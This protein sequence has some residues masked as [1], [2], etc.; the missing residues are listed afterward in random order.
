M[1][2]FD[3]TGWDYDYETEAYAKHI[4][5]LDSRDPEGYY[6]EYNRNTDQDINIP[7]WKDYVSEAQRAVY[8]FLGEPKVD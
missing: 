1:V 7:N 3:G 2:I 6:T 5:K 8:Y 4:C